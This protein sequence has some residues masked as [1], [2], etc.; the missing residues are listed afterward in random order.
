VTRADTLLQI[1]EAEAKAAQIVKDA[2]EKH[3]QVIAAA[4]REA[5]VRIQ[6]AEVKLKAEFESAF[7]AERAKISTQRD[8]IIRKGTIEAKSL[9]DRAESRV[10]KVVDDILE[11]FEQTL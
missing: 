4:R 9:T 1:K 2:E 6:A 7:S 8:E 3:K 10:A 11:K 5:A